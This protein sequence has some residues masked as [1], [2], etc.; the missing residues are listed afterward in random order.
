MRLDKYRPFFTKEHL[1][2]PNSLLLLDEILTCKPH[3]ISGGYVLDLGCGTGVTS[4]MLAQET[5]ADKVFAMDLWVA[6][7]DNWQRAKAWNQAEKIIPIHADANAMPFATAFFGSIVSVD[8]YHY[9]GYQKGFFSENILPHLA[10]GGHALLVM[11]GVREEGMQDH[12]LMQEWAGDETIMFHSPQWWKENLLHGAENITVKAW[13]S[14]RFNEAWNDW[15]ATGHDYALRDREFL[16]RGLKDML[17]FVLVDI[18]KK[19]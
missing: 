12:P 15:Y 9:F 6:A 17:N 4:L 13:E 8:A 14:A 11:P 16:E 19:A 1:M 3:A 18:C 2:G 10:V 5:A 7:G